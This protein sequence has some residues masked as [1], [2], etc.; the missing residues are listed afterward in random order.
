MIKIERERRL[1]FFEINKNIKISFLIF[2]MT[3]FFNCLFCVV[4]YLSYMT[5]TQGNKSLI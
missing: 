4:L 5:E 3:S 2:Y 1:F